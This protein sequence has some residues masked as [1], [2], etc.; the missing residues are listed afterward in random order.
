MWPSTSQVAMVGNSF[1]NIAM[2]AEQSECIPPAMLYCMYTFL[3]RIMHLSF[4]RLKI[5]ERNEE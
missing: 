3:P 4:N 5:H 1:V 2:H